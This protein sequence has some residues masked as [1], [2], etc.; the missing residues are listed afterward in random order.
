MKKSV[1]AVLVAVAAVLVIGFI[2][3]AG[4]DEAEAP[5]PAAGSASQEA[6]DAPSESSTG[7]ENPGSAT[8]DSIVIKDYAFAP[9]TITVKAGTTVTWTNQDADRHDITPDQETADFKASELLARG[10]SYSVTFTTPGTY[11]YYC[12]PHPYM[13]G[14]VEVVE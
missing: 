3:F 10:E 14:T 12:S 6:A 2:V 5:G 7:D 13:T 9:A 1:A 8:P 11:T 4:Q